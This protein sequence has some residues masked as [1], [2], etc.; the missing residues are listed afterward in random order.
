[1]QFYTNFSFLKKYEYFMKI[2]V[3]IMLYVD[4]F[5]IAEANFRPYLA[6]PMWSLDCKHGSYMSLEMLINL[7]LWNINTEYWVEIGHNI[8]NGII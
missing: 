5:Y 6:Q 4:K 2:L 8:A 7:R 1:M 3:T